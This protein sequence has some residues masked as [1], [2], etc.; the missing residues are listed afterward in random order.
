MNNLSWRAIRAFILVADA[1]SFTAAARDNG[2]SKANLSQLVTELETALGIQLLYRTTRQLRLTEIGEGYYCRCKQ[3][4]QQLDSAAEWACESK[5]GVEGKI[6][7][8]AVGGV[9]G[10][11]LIAPLVIDFQQ[12]NP[13]VRVH[14]DF[15]STRVNLIEDQYDLVIRMGALTDSSLI[16]RKL[17]SIKTCYVASPSFLQKHGPIAKPADL[18]SVPLISGSVDQWLLTRDK[19]QQVVQVDNSTKLVSGRV[20]HRAAL[21]GL[22]VTRL[23]D[24]YVQ[25]DINSGR[26]VEILPGWSESTELSMVCPP[27]RHQLARVRNLMQ[28]LKEG[29]SE[30]YSQTLQMGPIG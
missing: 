22:G 12:A 24:I 5:G 23:A 11:D 20:M 8:N 2:Y 19:S 21:T 9:I 10:E 18:A 14:L 30:R 15:S 7:I 25:A 6:R 28:W 29:F 17:H 16:V 27:L 3:A 26:L 4:M 1:G 13:G